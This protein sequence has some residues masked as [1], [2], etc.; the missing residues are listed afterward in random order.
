MPLNPSTP[1]ADQSAHPD[2]RLSTQ[3]S[4]KTKRTQIVM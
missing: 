4:E 3:K 2:K 1:D